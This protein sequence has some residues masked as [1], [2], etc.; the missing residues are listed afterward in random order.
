MRMIGWMALAVLVLAAGA[1]AG[2][3]AWR[4]MA[5]ADRS[6]EMLAVIIDGSDLAVPRALLRRKDS[7]ETWRDAVDLALRFPELDAMAADTP[8]ERRVFVAVQR[9][10]GSMDPAERPAEIYGRFLEPDLWQNP[11]G[12]LMRRFQAESPYADE[13][14][15][16]SPP[17]GRAFSARCRKTG[18]RPDLV[19]EACLWRYR[20]DG[21][22]VQVRFAPALL[23]RWEELAEGVRLRVR[24]LRRR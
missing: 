18:A 9:P 1:G 20:E 6:G 2:F 24:A 7:G 19:P 11:G 22:D 16:L 4:L 23:V 12:L 14:L 15:Y 3:L 13:D 5:P 17:E 8:P 10:D 21:L